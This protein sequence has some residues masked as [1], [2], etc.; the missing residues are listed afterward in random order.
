M[1]TP[2]KRPKTEEEST[3]SV[4]LRL[5]DPFIRT[6]G[7]LI[8]PIIKAETSI[9]VLLRLQEQNLQIILR[10]V[11]EETG[12]KTK[13]IKFWKSSS[14]RDLQGNLFIQCVSP[15][16]INEKKLNYF[17]KRLI[18]HLSENTT[19]KNIS[20]DQVDSTDEVI[21]QPM[22]SEP[23]FEMHKLELC[24]KTLSNIHPDSDETDGVSFIKDSIKK[25]LDE[26]KEKRTKIALL[27]QNGKGKSFLLNLLF[28]LTIDNAEE[29]QNNNRKLK[30][31]KDITGNPTIEELG[32]T[33]NQL[34][35][36]VK[37]FLKTYRNTQERFKT[38]MEP[39]CFELKPDNTH[40][41]DQSKNLFL[42]LPGYFKEGGRIKAE[43][44]MLAQKTLEHSCESTTKCIIHLRYG[45]VYQIKVDYFSSEDLKQ[46]LFELG[47]LSR[48]DTTNVD[49]EHGL[50][51]H[52][53]DKAY[54][55]LQT[56]F[57]ILTDSDVNENGLQ[58]FNTYHDIVLCEE[59]EEFAGRTELYFGSGRNSTQD[60]LALKAILK[61]VTSPQNS[62]SEEGKWKYRVAAA[63]EIVVYLPSKILYGGKEILEMPGTDDSDALALDFINKALS[64]ADAVFVMSDFAFNIVEKDVKDILRNCEFM[65]KW[66]K[67][68]ELYS[69]ML[70]TYPEKHLEFQFKNGDREEIEKLKKLEA[71]RRSNELK[72]FC[73]LLGMQSQSQKMD[74]A[75]FS[76]CILP[77]LHTSIHAQRGIPHQVIQEHACFLKYTGIKK[78]I[79]HLDSFISSSRKLDFQQLQKTLTTKTTKGLLPENARVLVQMYQNR[80]MKGTREDV[81]FRDYDKLLNNLSKN[82]DTVYT[83][84]L[85]KQV[86]NT[87]ANVAKEAVQLWDLNEENITSI[88]VFNPY[89]SGNHPTYKVKI[90]Q[91]I[92]NNIEDLTSEIFAFLMGEISEL[93]KVFKKDVVILFAEEL[94][95]IL[96]IYGH[97]NIDSRIFVRQAIQDVLSEAQ[98][99]YIGKQMK[100]INKHTVGKYVKESKKVM[101]KKYILIPAYNK[102]DLDL[103]KQLARKNMA[104][105]VMAVKEELKTRLLQLHY[106]R[107]TSFC[108]HLK[109]KRGIP[110][111][112]QVLLSKIKQSCHSTNTKQQQQPDTL[113]AVLKLITAKY[114]M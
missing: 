73:S 37:D 77:V 95:S 48:N 1:A 102:S 51:K 42:S 108:I 75:V 61:G 84:K 111:P 29:Y 74:D 105:A 2:Y 60:R 57:A 35:D 112:W 98:Q 24:Y 47:S 76:S 4:W 100:P 80:E 40:D 53:K 107:W 59:V 44:F 72:E 20:I 89:Y 14:D 54:E 93:L 52:I 11:Y 18:F 41:T 28:L 86:T 64:M 26:F 101:L 71:E 13:E 27:S 82:L 8:C 67:Y 69:L 85:V 17:K 32:E 30:L 83:S 104:Q 87:L 88:G 50:N 79:T 110:K 106:T 43:P 114:E 63:K 7:N 46:Q 34:P 6:D 99:W 16:I 33:I 92:L 21:P 65:Q 78:L 45:T 39:I 90:S 22:I 10:K 25:M 96:E 66:M 81:L 58:N 9:C 113:S 56:R 31:P 3:H 15:N 91:I 103:A 38:I 36:V 70:L 49:N 68:P 55:C 62:D 97:K 19:V 109:T 23:D 94:N 5:C 12:M